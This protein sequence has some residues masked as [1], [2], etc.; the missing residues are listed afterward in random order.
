MRK[1]E[2]KS[3]NIFKQLYK[4]AN[5]IKKKTKNILTSLEYAC[6]VNTLIMKKK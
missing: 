5:N 6:L 3:S 2:W 1:A 4:Q